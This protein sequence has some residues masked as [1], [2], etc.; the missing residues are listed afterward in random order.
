M[1][2]LQNSK[3]FVKGACEFK[4]SLPFFTIRHL[5]KLEKKCVVGHN[6]VYEQVTQILGHATKISSELLVH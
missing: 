2:F 6:V 5:Q 4:I 3:N 1:K